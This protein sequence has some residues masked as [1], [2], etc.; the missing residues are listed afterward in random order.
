MGSEV[1]RNAATRC[2]ITGTR[3]QK[4]PLTLCNHFYVRVPSIILLFVTPDPM[5]VPN[6]NFG[7]TLKGGENDLVIS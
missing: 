1:T 4:L 6:R 3:T 2:I 5:A 7:Y